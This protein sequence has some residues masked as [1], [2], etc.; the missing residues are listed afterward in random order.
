MP[1]SV[2]NLNFLSPLVTEIWRG[3]HTKNWELLISSDAPY[4]T[5]FYR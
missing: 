1:T 2:T 5:N 3:S 4:R